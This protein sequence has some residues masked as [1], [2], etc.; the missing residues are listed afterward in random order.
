[1]L[2]DVQGLMYITS[3]CHAY[4]ADWIFSQMQT[5]PKVHIFRCQLW[6][7]IGVDVGGDSIC[8]LIACG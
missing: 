3:Q 4:K 7:F 8:A 5:R 6:V 1:M 2:Y